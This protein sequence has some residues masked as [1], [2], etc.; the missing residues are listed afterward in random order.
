[1]SAGSIIIDLLMRTGSFETDTKRAEKRLKEFQKSVGEFGK[2]I[3]TVTT[4]AAAAFAFLAKQSIDSMDKMYKMAQVAGISTESLSGLAYAAQLAGV[5]QDDLTTSLVRLS[6]KLSDAQSGAEDAALAFKSIGLDANAYKSSDEALLALAE[7]FASFEDGA[8]KTALAVEFFG[9]SGAQLLPFLNAGKDGIEQLRNEAEKLGVVFSEDAAK[10]AEQFNDNVERLKVG[11]QG[12]VNEIT[13]RLLPSLNQ[14]VTGLNNIRDTSFWGWFTTSSA[15]EQNAAE[16]IDD[17]RKKIDNLQVTKDEL[18]KTSFLGWWNADDVKIVEFQIE[19]LTKK[20]EYLSKTILTVPQV[21][22]NWDTDS[23]ES[24]ISAK[25][26]KA[27]VLIKPAAASKGA[28]KISEYDQAVKRLTEE[29]ALLG[30]QTELE[31]TLEY[32]Q[33]GRYGKLNDEQTKTLSLLAETIDKQKESTEQWKQYSDFISEVTGRGDAEKFVQQMGW[34]ATAM[35]DGSM[36]AKQAQEAID[37][38]TSKLKESTDEMGEFAKEAARNI[39]DFLGD[40]LTQALEGNF[41][42]IGDSFVK[43]INR[44]MMQLAAAQ[45]NKMLFGA[46]D[47]TGDLGGVAGDVGGWLSG[48]F[49]P[50]AFATGGY[51]GSGGKYEPAGVVHKGEYVINAESTRSLGTAFLDKLNGKIGGSGSAGSVIVNV[52]PPQG[53]SR[54]SAQQWGAEAGRQIQRAMA[55]NT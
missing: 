31:K 54:S 1:M 3:A 25:K 30:K 34:I 42:D 32:I 38:M 23:I 18:Q 49:A 41:K 52:S 35:S 2:E 40:T 36:S 39:Q 19:S 10:S 20:M 29:L 27:P 11:L 14:F 17:I 46:F 53:S 50:K 28:D 8:N 51:T 44:M 21:S 13:V 15:E 47:K 7:R 48:M 24:A 43:M 5:G 4:A 45:L 22:V 9:R 6:T 33:L 16:T 26:T 55:R 12:L 37:N